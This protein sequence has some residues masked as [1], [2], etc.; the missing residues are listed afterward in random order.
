[1]A[2]REIKSMLDDVIM[3]P[4]QVGEYLHL[5]MSTVYRL[6]RCRQIPAVKIQ[7]QYRIS[8]NRLNQW[9]RDN[10]FSEIDIEGRQ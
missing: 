2:T 10:M 5:G 4:E 8:K 6:L 3:T 1:M 9:L 7:H